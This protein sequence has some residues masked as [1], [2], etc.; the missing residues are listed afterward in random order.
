M[1]SIYPRVLSI[2]EEDGVPEAVMDGST[3]TVG[4]EAEDGFEFKFSGTTT[5]RIE[6]GNVR[7]TTPAKC[8]EVKQTIPGFKLKGKSHTTAFSAPKGSAMFSEP[9]GNILSIHCAGAESAFAAPI[10]A[11]LIAMALCL[12]GNPSEPVNMKTVQSAI[13]VNPKNFFLGE[14][15]VKI[16]MD[17]LFQRYKTTLEC[18]YKSSGMPWCQVYVGG[19]GSSRVSIS[20]YASAKAIATGIPGDEDGD[21]SDEYSKL[22]ARIIVHTLMLANHPLVSGAGSSS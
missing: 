3:I 16:D 4:S 11:N 21:E 6:H 10:H 9:K 19:S 5:N 1:S 8:E 18:N 20:V 2:L 12:A 22:L 7:T 14:D 15:E 17:V 13:S